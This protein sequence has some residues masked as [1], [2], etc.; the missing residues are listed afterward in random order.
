MSR[1]ANPPA[2]NTPLAG[3]G[4]LSMAFGLVAPMPLMLPISVAVDDRFADIAL[5]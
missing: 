1:Y 5:W 2:N 4:F 3:L